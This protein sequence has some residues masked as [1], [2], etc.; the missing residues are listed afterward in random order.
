MVFTILSHF[1][2]GS[3]Q[4]ASAYVCVHESDYPG[5]RGGVRQTGPE[6]CVQ[7]ASPTGVVM[8]GTEEGREGLL[9]D[10]CRTAVVSHLESGRTRA[11]WEEWW[12]GPEAACGLWTDGEPQAYLPGAWAGGGPLS[13]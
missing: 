8:G 13:S 10:T 1:V 6:G 11:R 2:A 4:T 9:F 3:P 12:G 7:T 5:V